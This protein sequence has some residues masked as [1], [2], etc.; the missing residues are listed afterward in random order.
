[1]QNYRMSSPTRIYHYHRRRSRSL[2]KRTP[3]FSRWPY[4]TVSWLSRG[5]D[6]SGEVWIGCKRLILKLSGVLLAMKVKGPYMRPNQRLIL[7]QKWCDTRDIQL[8]GTGYY[9]RLRGSMSGWDYK[10]RSSRS[11][12]RKI[13]RISRTS[14]IVITSTSIYLF[15]S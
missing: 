8:T 6:S 1:M 11:S 12:S 3:C 2:H 15:I 4:G 10:C 5:P 13:S 14:G 9:R 7:I